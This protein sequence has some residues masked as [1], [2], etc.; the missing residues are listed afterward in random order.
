M[1]T[2]DALRRIATRVLYAHAH[3][4]YMAKTLWDKN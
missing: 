2:N 3:T 4:V 1:V